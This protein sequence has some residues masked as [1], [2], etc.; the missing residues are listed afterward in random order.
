MKVVAIGDAAL[1]DGFALLGIQTYADQTLEAINNVL[2]ELKTKHGRALV[3]MQQNLMKADIPM[4]ERLRN[5]G[6]S[7]LICE[8]PGLDQVNSF[9]PDVERMISRVMGSSVL[10][11]KHGD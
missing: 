10:E 2:R 5:Q 9:E 7:I 1:M 3:F 4:V 6:G 8:I 11:D